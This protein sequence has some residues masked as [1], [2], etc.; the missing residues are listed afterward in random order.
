VGG[1]GGGGGGGDGGGGGG[2][3]GD[4]G[5][6]GGLNHPVHARRLRGRLD[7][8]WPTSQLVAAIIDHRS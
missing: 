3:G 5:D 2:G 7:L 6:G 1:G 4:G 8:G